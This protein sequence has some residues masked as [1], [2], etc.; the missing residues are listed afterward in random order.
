MIVFSYYPND[1]RVR[2]E[3]EVL[4]RSS[5]GVD[6]ICLRHPDEERIARF[7]NV[8]AYRIMRGTEKKESI[9]KYFFITSI[10]AI[11]ALI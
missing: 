5:I 6:V 10:F 3:A 8:T 1:P 9:L 2:R 7:G 11:L 4:G